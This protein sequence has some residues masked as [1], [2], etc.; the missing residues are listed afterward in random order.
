LAGLKILEAP[1]IYLPPSELELK[2]KEN[3]I[4]R[5]LDERNKQFNYLLPLL[6]YELRLS[7]LTLVSQKKMT[8][9]HKIEDL[10]EY[11]IE[12]QGGFDKMDTIYSC[13]VIENLADD[14]KMVIKH[15]S[16]QHYEGGKGPLSYIV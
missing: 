5:D 11:L 13:Y 4:L 1:K 6:Q 15:F 8:V 2:E 7:I 12:R 10:M 14:D 9:Y 16:K 3:K